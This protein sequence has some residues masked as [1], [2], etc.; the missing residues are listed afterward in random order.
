MTDRFLHSFTISARAGEHEQEVTLYNKSD[1]RI[2]WF[3]YNMDYPYDARKK[4]IDSLWFYLGKEIS[5]CCFR[6]VFDECNYS[7]LYFLNGKLGTT[8]KE[9]C[10][11]EQLDQVYWIGDEQ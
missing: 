3:R 2:L 5:R 9:D 8:W 7:Q 10:R 4:I 11:F 6:I 1:E